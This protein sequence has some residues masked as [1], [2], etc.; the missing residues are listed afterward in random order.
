MKPM[1]RKSSLLQLQ[2][3]IQVPI[4]VYPFYILQDWVQRR[5]QEFRNEFSK[6]ES[7]LKLHMANN[8]KPSVQV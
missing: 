4:Q 2:T 7:E 1:P 8:I 3:M 6:K 5:E